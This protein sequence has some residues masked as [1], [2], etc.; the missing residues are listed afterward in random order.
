ME[1]LHCASSPQQVYINEVLPWKENAFKNLRQE[2][3]CLQIAIIYLEETS[4]RQ[5]RLPSNNEFAVFFA[6][7]QAEEDTLTL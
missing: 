2:N 3:V 5:F 4:E 6:K 7:K 1:V